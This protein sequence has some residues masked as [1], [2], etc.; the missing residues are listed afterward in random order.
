MVPIIIISNRKMHIMSRAG[1][2]LYARVPLLQKISIGDHNKA[3]KE[4]PLMTERQK[5]EAGNLCYRLE[6][7]FLIKK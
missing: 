2:Q 5:M 4:V 6:V 7:S 1:L 3:A